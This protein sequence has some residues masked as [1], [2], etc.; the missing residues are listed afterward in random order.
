M[1]K[2]ICSILCL[3]VIMG[4]FIY[5]QT[6]VEAYPTNYGEYSIDYVNDLDVKYGIVT[7]D[8]IQAL[9][10]NINEE[11][12]LGYVL[13][14]MARVHYLEKHPNVTLKS[15]PKDTVKYCIDNGI[16][17]DCLENY[18]VPLTRGAFAYLVTNAIKDKNMLEINNIADGVIPDVESDYFYK[19]AVYKCYKYGL[20]CGVDGKGTFDTETPITVYQTFIVLNRVMNPNLRQAVSLYNGDNIEVQSVEYPMYYKNITKG[21]EINITKERH[22]ETDCY[23]ANIKMNNPAHIKTIYSDL[24]WSGLGCEIST[25][26]KSINSIFMVNGDFRNKEFGEGLGIVRNRMIVNDKKFNKVLAM[27]LEGNLVK[28]N[29]TSAQAVLNQGIR[30]TWTF[31]P[32]LIE[33]SKVLNVN[34]EAR[35][36][37]TFIGQVNREDGILEYVIVVADGRSLT[38]AG[39]TMKECANILEMNHCDIGYNLDGGGSS[40]MMF[41]G[42]VLNDPCYGERADIDYIY[43]K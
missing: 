33:N 18:D 36:P 5:P 1:K 32:W 31:G 37:R 8:E 19:D 38:N 2:V 27:D 26:N 20:I 21:L 23:V 9:S 13:T 22:Y 4:Y 30:D 14:L 15:V 42:K 29:E 12:D 10:E 6:K 17:D 41:M 7:E 25:F 43:I 24:E 3:A 16:F 34:N 28:V 39:L 40:V 35:A 11:I